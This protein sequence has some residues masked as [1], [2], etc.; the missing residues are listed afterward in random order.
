MATVP[1]IDT[2]AS[3]LLALHDAGGIVAPLSAR[4]PDLTAEAG[5]RAA[6]RLHAVRVARGWKPLGRKIG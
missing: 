6:A 5:Y 2:L 3:E 4:Y 1:D